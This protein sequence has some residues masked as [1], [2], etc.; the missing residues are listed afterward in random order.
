VSILEYIRTAIQEG[1]VEFS[2]EMF[3]ILD[4]GW[5]DIPNYVVVYPFW[6]D[7]RDAVDGTDYRVGFLPSLCVLCKYHRTGVLMFGQK[8]YYVCGGTFEIYDFAFRV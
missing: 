4:V 2:D 6:E 5:E 3:G 7:L 1:F 8:V